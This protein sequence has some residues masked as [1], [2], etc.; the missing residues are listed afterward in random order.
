MCYSQSLCCFVIRVRLVWENSLDKGKATQSSIL[1]WRIPWTEEPGGL[2][3]LG[4]HR[5]R[6]D[7]VTNTFT[8]FSFIDI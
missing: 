5:V 3:F 2:Q 1:S 8:T 4:S 6:H 7:W